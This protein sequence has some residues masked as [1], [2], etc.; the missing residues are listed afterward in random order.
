MFNSF[1]YTSKRIRYCFKNTGVIYKLGGMY[2]FSNQFDL[3]HCAVEKVLLHLLYSVYHNT[4]P[5]ALIYEMDLSSSPVSSDLVSNELSYDVNTS[6]NDQSTCRV[7][8][9]PGN[10]TL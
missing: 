6:V 8:D 2:W 10:K 1:I 7:C 3:W 4:N 9:V 5:W